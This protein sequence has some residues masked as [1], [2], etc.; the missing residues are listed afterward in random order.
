M[1]APGCL[2]LRAAK[3]AV[4]EAAVHAI[5]EIFAD[6]GTKDIMLV[7][8]SNAF[9]SLNRCE[10]LLNMFRLCPPLATILTNT[11]QSASYLFIDGSSLL[12]QEG[13]TQG[14]PLAIPKYTIGIVLVIRQLT[15]L[16]R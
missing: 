10:V 14:N 11:Y 16:A 2:Q 1:D 3:C 6:E 13:T 4:C 7:D 12:S 9:N 8:A 5:R 15:G